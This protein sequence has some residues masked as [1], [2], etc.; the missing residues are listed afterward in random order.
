MLRKLRERIQSEESGFTLIELLVVILIIGIL[1]A[2]ALP[3]FL[4]QRT[5]AQDADTKSAA[6]NA[7]TAIESCYADT[8]DFTQCLTPPDMPA[9]ATVD[10]APATGTDFYKV[11]A[12]GNGRTF[13]IAK[14][15]AGVYTRSCGSGGTGGCK[16]G[17]SW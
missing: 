4:S 13:S 6:R 15:N 16:T 1:A 7:V 5:K 2:I 17:G 3:A 11:T 10:A 9:G 8:Q 12:T 14:S